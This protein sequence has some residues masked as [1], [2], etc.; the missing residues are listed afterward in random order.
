MTT[1]HSII[2]DWTPRFKRAFK[3]IPKQTQLLFG[4]RIA[5]FEDDWRHP[6]LRV[7]R[8]EGTEGIW[9]ASVNMS[10]RFT[11]SWLK[12]EHGYE[13]CQLRNIGDHDHCLRPP[14]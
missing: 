7:K 10:I 4:D 3:K 13:I 1:E 14:F 5:Q 11:F 9:E 6:S 2:F 8:I 12:D